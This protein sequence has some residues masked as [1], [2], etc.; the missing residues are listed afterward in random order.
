MISSRLS[1]DEIVASL[2]TWGKG[3]VESF[4]GRE[5]SKIPC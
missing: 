1:P 4:R 3:E 2:G 5:R